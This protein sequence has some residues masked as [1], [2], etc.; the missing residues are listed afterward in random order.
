M[1][2]S[3]IFS[4]VG[5]SSAALLKTSSQSSLAA[6]LGPA[7]NFSKE[8]SKDCAEGKF[9]PGC[10]ADKFARYS[11]LFCATD[12]SGSIKPLADERMLDLKAKR[13]AASKE[14]PKE[15]GM[16]KWVTDFIAKE[17]MS[18]CPLMASVQT[19]AP[20]S[21]CEYKVATKD[22]ELKK[23]NAASIAGI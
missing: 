19:G 23:Y 5:A 13:G 4:M 14:S 20:T 18:T 3:V 22:G 15:D 10:D 21:P 17:G 8:Q 9:L 6:T 12:A 2:L 11:L 7:Y 1:R 16:Q